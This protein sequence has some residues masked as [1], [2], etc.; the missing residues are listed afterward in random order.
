LTKIIIGSE[1]DFGLFSLVQLSRVVQMINQQITFV[2]L[3]SI[4]LEK[5]YICN[6]SFSCVWG[7][8]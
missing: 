3:L 6:T 1:Q 8:H 5:C 2:E 7:C 4:I